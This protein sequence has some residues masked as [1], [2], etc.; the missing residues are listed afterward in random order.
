VRNIL[1]L[2]AFVAVTFLAAAVGGRNM[3]GEWYLSLRKPDWNPPS[4]V[5]G[6]VWS[7]LYLMIAVAGWRAWRATGSVTHPAVIL[8]AAQLALNAAWSWLFFGLHRPDLAFL[9]IAA[10]W[11]LIVACVVAFRGV[12]VVAAWL[13]V[14]YLLWVTFASA[15][16]LRIWMLNR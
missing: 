5:F 16:N 2:G 7:A 13:F 9:D 6:P 14:P 1:A 10:M 8:W 12:D 11:A 4:W 3:P 15:L